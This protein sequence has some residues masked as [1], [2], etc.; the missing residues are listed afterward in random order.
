M[1][2]DIVK[3]IMRVALALVV[4]GCG[5]PPYIFGGLY[6]SAPA[7]Y[8]DFYDE[9]GAAG[10]VGVGLEF[11]NGVSCELRHRSMVFNTPEA[12]TNDAGCEAR[13]YFGERDN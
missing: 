13:K 1:R 6:Y 4:S 9:T 3:W 8:P 12:V 11:S 7:G 2:F 5:S 10:A